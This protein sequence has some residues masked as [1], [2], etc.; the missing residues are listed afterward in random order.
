[1][2]VLILLRNGQSHADARQA[3]AGLLDP[4]LTPTG[5]AEAQT[6]ADL[7]ASRGVHL[8]VVM[9]SPQARAVQTA[10]AVLA[11]L[12][13]A[14]LPRVT[15]WRLAARDLG[16]LTGVAKPRAISLFG[17]ESMTEWRF[18]PGGKPPAASPERIRALPWR[19]TADFLQS[20]PF[21]EGESLREVEERLRPFWEGALRTELAAGRAVLVVA[22]T[23]SLRALR[24]VIESCG[25]DEVDTLRVVPGQPL[26]YRTDASGSVVPPA[27]YLENHASL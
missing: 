5:V 8:D 10:D 11:R 13:Q 12:D 23:D 14:E 22:H 3:Y 7:L 20:L 19:P 27:L 1:M 2:T 4:E 9:T 24:R 21:G 17:A 15:S 26:A 16:C 6:V 18:S 25:P